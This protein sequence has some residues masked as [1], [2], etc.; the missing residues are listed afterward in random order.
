M[1]QLTEAPAGNGA[2]SGG[3][4]FDSW[5]ELLWTFNFRTPEERSER[6]NVKNPLSE[7]EGYVLC[8]IEQEKKTPQ[9]NGGEAI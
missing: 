4:R 6:G 9:K 7:V 3:S 5:A 2:H 1:A 8:C